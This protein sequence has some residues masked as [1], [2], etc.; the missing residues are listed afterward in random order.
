MSSPFDTIV[1]PITGSGRAAVA[2]VRLSGPDSWE[3]AAKVFA[4][5]PIEPQ[6]RFALYGRFANGDDG[7]ALPF[8][9]GKSYTAEPCVELSCHGSP[10][11]VKTIVNDCVRSGAR[12]AEPGE[13][14]LRAFLNGRIDL[15][16][17]EAV[18]DT[19][20]SLTAAQLRMA[21]LQRDGALHTE[22]SAIRVMAIKCLASV[23]ASVDFEE[24]IGPVDRKALL[25]DL[26]EMS[27]RIESLLATAAAGRLLRKGL[28]IAIVGPPN[29][30][31]SSLLNALLGVDRAIVTDIPGTTRDYM[32]EATDFGGVPV[33]LIDTAGIRQTNDPIESIGLQRTRLQSENADV[34]WYVYDAALGFTEID[35][36]NLRTFGQ[37]VIVVANKV[38]LAPVKSPDQIGVSAKALLGLDNLVGTVSA[39]ARE[40]ISLELPPINERHTPLL[41]E[42]SGSL[43]NLIALAKSNKPDDLLSVGLSGIIDGLGQIT[44]ETASVDM[45]E[46]IFHD[47]CIGK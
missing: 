2:I 34:V 37:Q 39:M 38:D 5:W 17:A 36:Q 16:E 12:L 21:N 47:F 25:E 9:A 20:E 30:G 42:C 14:T 40:A 43:T 31:K 23:E 22:V 33:V 24:E 13:F 15:T 19:V 29:A 10:H 41:Q 8:D 6:P 4:P 28:R 3:I 18:R 26:Q 35:E 27:C 11:S 46:R 1:A 44:G 45:I 32:E 7:F